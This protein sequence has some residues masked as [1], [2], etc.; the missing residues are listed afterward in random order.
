M[1][2]LRVGLVGDQEIL[3]DKNITSV[4]CIFLK[5]LD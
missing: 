2:L 5:W 3:V 4:A 1:G